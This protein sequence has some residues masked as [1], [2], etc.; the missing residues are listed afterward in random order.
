MKA[1]PFKL[2][3]PLTVESKLKCELK[4]ECELTCELTCKLTCNLKLK[5]E[6]RLYLEGLHAVVELGHAEVIAQRGVTHRVQL[7]C[8]RL[9]KSLRKFH[10]S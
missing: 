10:Q 8:T 5:C 7:L 1:T 4:C 6:L 9:F 3:L 2:S